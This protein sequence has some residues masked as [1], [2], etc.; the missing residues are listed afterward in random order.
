VS[1]LPSR[2][3]MPSED[4][5]SEVCMQVDE[6]AAGEPTMPKKFSLPTPPRVSMTETTFRNLC[7][8]LEL[9]V[10]PTYSDD[11][12]Q[13]RLAMTWFTVNQALSKDKS[14]RPRLANQD[15]FKKNLDKIG[16]L[17]FVKLLKDIARKQS[18]RDL[19]EHGTYILHLI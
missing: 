9:D 17:S 18:W 4:D 1:P 14:L 11:L 6:P 16:E 12:I 13:Q 7:Q 15:Q 10:R 8:N 2:L 3:P 19:L 5:I